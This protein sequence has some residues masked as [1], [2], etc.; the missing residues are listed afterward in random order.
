MNCRE[1]AMRPNKELANELLS[2]RKE[3]TQKYGT[4]SDS[5]AL[6]RAERDERCLNVTSSI[7][8]AH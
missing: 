1:I 8:S 5:T 4:F 6:I 2:M 3:L 7:K